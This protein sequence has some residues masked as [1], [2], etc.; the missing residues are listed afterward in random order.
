VIRD[1]NAVVEELSTA[2]ERVQVGAN[3][4]ACRAL[5]KDAVDSGRASLDY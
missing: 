3:L 4:D 2:F 5:A 1:V